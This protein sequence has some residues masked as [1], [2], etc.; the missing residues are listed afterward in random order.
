MK[1]T[2]L[3]MN[4]VT[5]KFIR[6]TIKYKKG[7]LM[8]NNCLYNKIKLLHDLCSTHWFIHQ[9]A[10]C[11]AQDMKDTECIAYL[12]ELEQDLKKHIEK[13]KNMTCK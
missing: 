7:K 6:N 4:M 9:H 1:K 12:E 2:V 5:Q 8:I 13:L 10:K 3:S 11:D